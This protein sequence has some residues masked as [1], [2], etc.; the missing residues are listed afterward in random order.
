V[1][2]LT[3]VTVTGLCLV[4]TNLLL[5]AC[6]AADEPVAQS[7]LAFTPAG[8]EYHFYTRPFRGTLRQGGKSLGVVPVIDSTSGRSLTGQFGLLSFYRILTADTRYGTA[9]WDWSSQ[10]RLLDSGAVEVNWRPDKDH[11]LALT[12]VYRWTAPGVLDVRAT[13]KPQQDMKRFEL[14]LASYFA[15]FHAA[16]GYAEQAGKPTWVEARRSDGDWQTFPRDAAA[17]KIFADGRWKR[18]PNPVQWK[19]RP[20]L[21]AP[22]GM[23]KDAKNGLTAVVMAPAANC[24]GVSMPY[25][26]EGH[27]SIYLSLFGRDLTAGQAATVR[28]RLVIGRELSDEQIMA[29]YRE[30]KCAVGN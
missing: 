18:P 22:M 20:Y 21:A 24:F 15:G 29:R 5:A 11:P 13:V 12:A 28:A 19:M 23:R 16:F 30:L 1:K 26:E 8:N 14:F 9:A 25:G 7:N 27:G 3:K 2:L 17:A 6:A 10:S 4:S